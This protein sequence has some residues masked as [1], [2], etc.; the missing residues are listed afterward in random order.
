M[1]LRVKLPLIFLPLVAIP[2]LIVG[3]VA[4]VQLRDSAEK[5]S[6][7]QVVTLLEQIDIQVDNL[8]DN[9]SSNLDLFSEYPLIKQY[10]LAESEEERYTVLFR[11]IQRQFL[12]IQKAYPEYSE[13]RVILPDGFEDVR[14]VNRD[15][16]NLTEEEHNSPFFVELKNSSSE[17]VVRFD[18]N[19]DNN[20]L[21]CYVSKRINLI[22]E[23][24]DDPAAEPRLRGYLSA[25]LD[26]THLL[27]QLENNPLGE[28]SGIFLTDD[29]GQMMYLPEHIKW[30]SSENLPLGGLQSKYHETIEQQVPLAGDDFKLSSHKLQNN[31]CLLYTSPSPRD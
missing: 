12:N 7:T 28:Q 1:K 22:N 25:T 26:V 21:V 27:S 14:L 6:V 19:P 15:I 5:S 11:P 29:K 9:T 30:L 8:V 23:A 2:L 16:P 10:F 24:L 17:F 4:Y 31:L 20:E 18:R 13:L 3:M